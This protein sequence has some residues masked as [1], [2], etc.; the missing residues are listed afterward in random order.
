LLDEVALPD[1]QEAHDRGDERDD[2]RNHRAASV[3][4]LPEAVCSGI[5][6]S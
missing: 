1:R 6:P 2:Y 3:V 4:A 5:T